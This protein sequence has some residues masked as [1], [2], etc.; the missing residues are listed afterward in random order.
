MIYFSSL[1]T[2][3]IKILNQIN[4][5]Q[6]QRLLLVTTSIHEIKSETILPFDPITHDFDGKQT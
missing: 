6:I 5:Q 2:R 4:Y 3:T 1:E